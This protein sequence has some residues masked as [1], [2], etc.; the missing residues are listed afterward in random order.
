MQFSV[1]YEFD[2]P[3]DHSTQRYTPSQRYLFTMTERSD[4]EPS[5]WCAELFN[6]KCK[7]R[8]LCAILTRKQFEKFIQDTGLFAKDVETMGSIGAPG[9]GYGCVPAISFC[10]DDPAAIQSAYVT[11]FPSFEG[12]TGVSDSEK[13]WQNIR[14]A[15]IAQYRS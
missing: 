4:G 5:D 8:K 6:G 3:M 10:N 2:C 14:T 11:P 13:N 9:F 12:T 15:V 1:I 7:H